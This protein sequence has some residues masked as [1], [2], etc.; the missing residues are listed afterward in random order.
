MS[1]SRSKVAMLPCS[2]RFVRRRGLP[3]DEQGGQRQRHVD[4][5]QRLP[6]DQAHQQPADHRADRGPGGV[7]HLDAAQRLC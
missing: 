6:A 7:G 3:H 1:E 4:Q 2:R 5:E